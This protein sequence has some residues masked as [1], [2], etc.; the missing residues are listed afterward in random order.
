MHEL[1]QAAAHFAAQHLNYVLDVL[2]L[3]AVAA[4]MAM[5]DKIPASLQ[6]VWT[7]AR[8]TLQTAIPVKRPMQHNSSS[9]EP[10]K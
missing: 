3:L 9:A 7:W 4:V 5:P 8:E 10:G 2:G 1:G 6:D